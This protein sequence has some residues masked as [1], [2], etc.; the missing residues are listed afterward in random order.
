MTN[1]RS[2]DVVEVRLVRAEA[3]A[4]PEATS[5]WFLTGHPCRRRPNDRSA[6]VRRSGMD[7]KRPDVDLDEKP[8][9]E[10]LVTKRDH[11]EDEDRD[12]RS[13]PNALRRF[14]DR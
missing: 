9:E 13:V 2:P 5:S 7:S 4:E 1:S 6:G 10:G 3:A 12:D 14:F 11:D 8:D